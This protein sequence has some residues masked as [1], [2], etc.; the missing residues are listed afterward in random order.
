MDDLLNRML[1]ID[2]E[3]EEIVRQAQR[4]AAALIA[5]GRTAAQQEQHEIQQAL[6]RECAELR[7]REMARV[8]AENRERLHQLATEMCG[9]VAAFAAAAGHVRGDIYQALT[10]GTTHS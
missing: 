10:L 7:Q 3:A 4:E 6:N 2:E 5:A 1:A 9:Q 8:E